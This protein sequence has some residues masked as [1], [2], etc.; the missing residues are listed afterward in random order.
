MLFLLVF[1]SCCIGAVCGFGGGV[2]IKPVLDFVQYDSTQ[3]VNFL[4]GCTVLSMSLY[5]VVSSFVRREKS[6]KTAVSTPLAVGAIAGGML[7]KEIFSYLLAHAVQPGMVSGIQ[8]VVLVVLT[9]CCLLY[10]L[11]KKHI[12]PL[13]TKSILTACGIGVFL[14]TVSGFLGIGG[15]QFNLIVLYFFFGMDTKT[16]A[17]NS[18]YIILLSKISNLVMQIC[19][20]SIPEFEYSSLAVMILAGIL[21]GI[22]GRF[23]NR[24]VADKTV[25]RLLVGVLCIVIV[26]C[27]CN[28]ISGFT[29]R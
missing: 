18:L 20:H 12:H 23:V 7:G 19:T 26:I 16:A 2:V 21:G 3:V 27:C 22:I 15:G 6:V 8:A 17:T 29:G 28:M 24:K 1:V 14:G 11:L 4:S 25:D 9:L 10:I 5:T 13:H